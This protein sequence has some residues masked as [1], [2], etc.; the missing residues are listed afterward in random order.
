MSISEPRLREASRLRAP[1]L[2]ALIGCLALAAA[3]SEAQPRPQEPLGATIADT[4]S[5]T[6]RFRTISLASADGRRRYRVQIAEPRR[7]P[8][9]AGRQVIYLLDGNG[10]VAALD[11]ALLAK[12]DAA[13][14]PPVLV[15][16]GYDVDTRFDV[17]ARAFDYTPPG[18]EGR[19][20]A[21]PAGRPG[22]G[23]DAF[24]DLVERDI[25]PRVEAQA[26]IDRRRQTLWGHSYGGL[27]TVY[28]ALSRPQAFQHYVAA[29]PSLWWNGGAVLDREAGFADDPR[30]R[31]L[32]LDIV[33]GGA[34]GQGSGGPRPGGPM[35]NTL[36]P[37]S[38]E[39]L[40]RRL[41]DVG[42][43]VRFEEI[44]GESHGSMFAASLTRTL[45]FLAKTQHLP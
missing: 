9:P 24:L 38:S 5:Q 41:R 21:D 4:G 18:A 30:R 13:G 16:I 28:A 11:E 3:P 37:G 34:E 45:T 43:D 31:N 7:S 17:Q 1:A 33:V 14:D 2:A 44:P 23:A 15:A 29:S 10:A 42:A 25:R 20:A 36:P 6:Y 32:R 19:P 27:L 26:R 8:P 12:L 40:A 22:G 39:A 35:R